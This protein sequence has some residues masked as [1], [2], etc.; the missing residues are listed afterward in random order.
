MS[1]IGRELFEVS[2]TYRAEHSL[3]AQLALEIS[4]NSQ[5]T[6]VLHLIST[7]STDGEL[8]RPQHNL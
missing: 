1:G 5:G 4:H 6:P 3:A 8:E 2:G 7:L